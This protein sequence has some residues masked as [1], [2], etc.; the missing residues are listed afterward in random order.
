M[1]SSPPL[2]WF[3]DLKPFT[4][5]TVLNE[6]ESWFKFLSIQSFNPVL[7]CFI[8][9]HFV[10][11]RQYLSAVENQGPGIVIIAKLN[12]RWQFL[13]DIAFSAKLTR[14]NIS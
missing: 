2:S 6:R 11:Q 5:Q 14:I 8:I 3:Y 4:T 1:F 10:L 12:L 7:M 13:L 9:T